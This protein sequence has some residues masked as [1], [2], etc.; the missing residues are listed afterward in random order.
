MMYVQSLTIEICFHLHLL[1]VEGCSVPLK[2]Q[3]LDCCSGPTSQS[4]SNV[5]LMQ[6]WFWNLRPHTLHLHWEWTLQ[7]FR[8]HPVSNRKAWE[9]NKLG[10][11]IDS[12]ICNEVY[13]QCNLAVTSG[14][15]ASSQ[16]C[17]HLDRR[18]SFAMG[19]CVLKAEIQYYS[20][21]MLRHWNNLRRHCT[22]EM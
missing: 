9:M 19:V 7:W 2:N 3:I 6:L 8:R 16:Q 5:Q 1:E 13:L 11:F 12:G 20:C 4:W 17:C 21:F 15:A 22:L 10:I 18:M 14:F